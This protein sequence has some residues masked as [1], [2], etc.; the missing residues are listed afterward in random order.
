MRCTDTDHMETGPW[1]SQLEQKVRPK[2]MNRK[3]KPLSYFS[4]RKM[5]TPG[6]QS[7]IPHSWA[8]YCTTAITESGTCPFRLLHRVGQHLLEGAHREGLVQ[9][10]GTDGQV[11]GD[12]LCGEGKPSVCHLCQTPMSVY[13]CALQV[14]SQTDWVFVTS[15]HE[16]PIFRTHCPCYAHLVQFLN[17]WKAAVSVMVHFLWHTSHWEIYS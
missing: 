16:L 5:A 12:I 15:H 4:E 8:H 3:E 9:H 10:K 6:E 17:S 14:P 11:R 7:F 13:L 1:V 2:G